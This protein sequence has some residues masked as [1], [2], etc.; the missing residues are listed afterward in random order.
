MQKLLELNN[1]LGATGVFFGTQMMASQRLK[2]T[3]KVQKS[4]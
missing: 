2:Q 3:W 1:F 4:L